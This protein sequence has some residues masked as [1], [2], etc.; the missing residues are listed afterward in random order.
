MVPYRALTP[1]SCPRCHHVQQLHELAITNPFLPAWRES[2]CNDVARRCGRCG[3]IAPTRDF[4][5]ADERRLPLSDVD[6][7]DLAHPDA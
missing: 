3:L 6:D 2:A 4:R 7:H 5:T 1:R